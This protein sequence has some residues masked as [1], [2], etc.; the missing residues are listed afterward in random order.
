[1]PAGLLKQCFMFVAEIDPFLFGSATFRE[2]TWMDWVERSPW[3]RPLR[4]G[5]K[6]ERSQMAACILSSG[7]MP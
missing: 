6:F 7:Q 4:S 5:S 2:M 1:M 3:R